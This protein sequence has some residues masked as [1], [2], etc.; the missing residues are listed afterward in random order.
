MSA[1]EGYDTW[2]RLNDNSSFSSGTLS[3]KL[4]RSDE[5]LQVGSGGANFYANSSGNGYIQNTFG[6]HGTDT[7]KHF[8]VNGTSRFADDITM[9][10]GS[11]ILF[12]PNTQYLRWTT[13]TSNNNSTGRSWYGIGTYQNTSD[14]N[15]SW[16]NISNY[17]GINITTKGNTCLRHNNN[18]IP[19]TN[20]QTGTVGSTSQPVYINGGAVTAI[21]GTLANSISG[22]ANRAQLLRNYYVDTAGNANSAN[23]PSSANLATTG[24]GGLVTFKA[25]KSMTTAKPPSDAHILH[26][27][28]DNTGGYDAQIAVQ[29]GNST[30]YSRGCNAGTWN[31]WKTILDSNN[32]TSYTVTKTG[33]GASGTWGINISG[34]AATATKLATARSI[35]IGAASKTF[36]GT[37]NISYTPYEMK[38]VRALYNTDSNLNAFANRGHAL[39]MC[40]LADNGSVDN[41]GGKTGWHHVINL[42]WVDAADNNGST[43]NE[44][45][46]QIANACGSSDLYVR[47]RGGGSITN[48]TAWVAPWTKIL[49]DANYGSIAD[50]RYVKKSGDTMTGMLQVNN[51]PIFGYRYGQSN[52][53]P[54]FVFDKPGSHYTGIGTNGDTDTIYFGAVSTDNNWNWVTSYQQKWVFNGTVIAGSKLRLWTDSEGGNIDIIDNSSTRHYQIDAYNGSL[55]LYSQLC[56]DNSGY[57]GITLLDTNGYSHFNKAYGA[58]WNDYAEYRQTI[59]IISAGQC[60]IETGFGDLVKSTKRLQPGANIVSDT[61]GFAIGETEQTKTPIAVSGRVLAYPYEDRNSYQAGDPVCSGPNGTIS[62]MTREEVRKY[63]DRIVGTVSEI[64]E[65]EEWGTGKVKVD[66]RIWIKVR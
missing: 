43:A 26:M 19:H 40:E 56:S 23:R 57:F 14:S 21:T 5:A 7:T 55:R 53:A 63:P 17:W 20:N 9:D 2:L 62:K 36:D 52:N 45:C 58:V 48:G 35:T 61:F 41:P 33:G 25:T 3:P 50:N 6:V 47:S 10:N 46:T 11:E 28:W 49:T 24:S 18:V 31:P 1:I 37:A 64:P 65:Y 39:G 54:A 4:I 29:T 59:K 22:N 42:T 60:V 38:L 8:F 15:N 30:I 27:F 66:G 51:A 34:N 13:D 16:L 44:W 32:Y 12:S